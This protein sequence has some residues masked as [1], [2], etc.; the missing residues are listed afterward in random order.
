MQAVRF[1]CGRCGKQMQVG[2]NLLGKQVRC[3][4][5]QQVILAPASAPVP[6]PAAPVAAA[7]V[8]F[9][10]PQRN[11][12][13]DSIFG[14]PEGSDDL[15][16]HRPRVPTV[17]MPQ[18]P[19]PPAAAVD[20][21]TEALSAPT[22]A[23]APSVSAPSENQW[24]GPGQAAAGDL[25]IASNLARR[26]VQQR[27]KQ[28]SMLTIYILIFLIPYALLMTVAALWFYSRSQAIVDPFEKELDWPRESPDP[29]QKLKKGGTYNRHDDSRPLPAKLRTTLGK[30]LPIGDLLVTPLQVE[31]RPIE[32]VS[33]RSGIQSVLT[34]NDAMV[35]TLE[36][37]NR[38]E[39]IRFAP[40]DLYYNRKWKD[41]RAPSSRPYTALEVGRLR[42]YGGAEEWWSRTAKPSLWRE[43]R[44]DARYYVRGQE[45]DKELNP[46]EKMT[47]I[48]CT[49]PEN[50]DVLDTLD[51]YEGPLLWR[52]QLRRGVVKV[53]DRGLASAT[54]VIGVEFD[55]SA[56][57]QK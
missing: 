10:L 21:P 26:L 30:P 44:E 3:P 57:K 18:A 53:R 47:M 31:R 8:T 52:V 34:K 36:V 14:E 12:E 37:E 45:H 46:G 22:A 24:D 23:A 7:E 27:A 16:D 43:K 13:D 33:E 4:H 48:V 28:D 15:F 56:I 5:C 35:L 17:D 19:S 20:A 38:S 1:Q 25:P 41:D 54:A 2:A 42:F 51:R 49:D 9:R 50:A 39:D 40:N 55:K 11:E 29:Y 6:A 32:L